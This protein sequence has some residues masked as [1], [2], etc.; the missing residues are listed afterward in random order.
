MNIHAK[1]DSSFGE[2]TIGALLQRLAEHPQK[3][4]VFSYDGKSV[5][6]GYHVT[7]VKT[8][9]FDAIDCGANP[10][11]WEETF[12]QL[13]DIDGESASHMAAAKFSAIMRKVAQSVKIDPEGKLTFEVS[14]GVKPMQI[15]RA[16]KLS[17]DAERVMI[18][19]SARPSSCK[20]RDRWLDPAP[21]VSACCGKAGC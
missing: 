17:T 18:E 7:E 12:I 10:E 20:P 4:L 15:Y 9:R 6:P 19:L 21:R 11:Q 1:T 16:D 13:W 3:K 2:L 5:K 14:D 8:G